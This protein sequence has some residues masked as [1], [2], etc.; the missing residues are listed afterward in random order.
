MRDARAICDEPDVSK[1]IGISSRL[2]R[3]EPA[4]E[5][6]CIAPTRAPQTVNLASIGRAIEH[7]KRLKRH[8]RSPIV[9]DSALVLRYFRRE[10]LIR[11][12]RVS[13]NWVHPLPSER[14]DVWTAQTVIRQFP[15]AA[16]DDLLSPFRYERRWGQR[17]ALCSSYGS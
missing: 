4:R 6:R 14:R 5:I 15:R 10:I 1:W 12:F 9:C 2:P 17:S 7:A 11:R 8:Y 3:G 13:R 16:R